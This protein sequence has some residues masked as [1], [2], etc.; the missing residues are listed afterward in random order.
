MKNKRQYRDS[1]MFAF[2][3]YVGII[4]IVLALLLGIGS[5][6][7]FNKEVQEGINNDPR[8]ANHLMN[9]LPPSFYDT[10]TPQDSLELKEPDMIY[11]DTTSRWEGKEGKSEFGEYVPNEKYEDEHVMWITGEGDTIWE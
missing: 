10:L 2:I 8:P 5:C 4:V 7:D 1:A 11:M 3:G 6:T 9:Y